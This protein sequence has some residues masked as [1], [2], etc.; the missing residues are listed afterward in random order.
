MP[1]LALVILLLTH[2]CQK[3]YSQNLNKDSTCLP[4]PIAKEFE[5]F[6]G[7]VNDI[8]FYNDEMWVVGKDQ[9][10]RRYKEKTWFVESGFAK[11]ISIDASGAPWIIGIDSRVYYRHQGDW[12][13]KFQ[14]A[15]G[16]QAGSWRTIIFG[17][18]KD[19]NPFKISIHQNNRWLQ[20]IKKGAKAMLDKDGDLWILDVK[21]TLH[22]KSRI[23]KTEVRDFAL[24]R[25][26]QP[27]II[28]NTGSIK[29][30]IRREN[31]W[32]TLFK[33]HPIIKHARLFIDPKENIWL[34]RSSGQLLRKKGIDLKGFGLFQ[35]GYKLVDSN[36]KCIH[37]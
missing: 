33:A 9:K 7:R 25:L 11:Q 6:E 31:R 26:N 2:S 16:I 4:K 8:D 3:P 18:K 35:K 37:L 30:L 5:S 27:Y 14:T 17:G 13:R 22:H 34:L 21:D 10:I 28:D 24:G 1:L 15:Q 32:D 29:K 36:L 19:L 12:H 20:A 23:I